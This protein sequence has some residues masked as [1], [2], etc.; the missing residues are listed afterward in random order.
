[1]EALTPIGARCVD[2]SVMAD[3]LINQALVHVLH[4]NRSFHGVLSIPHRSDG[5]GFF[6]VGAV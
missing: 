1:M 2:T 4:F 5:E 3:V 6:R